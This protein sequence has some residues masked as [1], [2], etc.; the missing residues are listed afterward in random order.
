MS[1]VHTIRSIIPY[2]FRITASNQWFEY[3]QI[4]GFTIFRITLSNLWFHTSLDSHSQISPMAF[5]IFCIEL[6]PNYPSFIFGVLLT[7]STFITHQKKRQKGCTHCNN[8]EWMEGYQTLLNAKIVRWSGMQGLSKWVIY[9]CWHT[10]NN[11]NNNNNNHNNNNNSMSRDASRQTCPKLK[12]KKKK[13]TC[14]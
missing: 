14:K 2:V 11:N 9:C 3:H 5:V 8:S 1:L 13:I 10:I 7:L 6:E 4:N 12:K